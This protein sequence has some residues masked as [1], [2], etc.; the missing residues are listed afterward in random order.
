M[1]SYNGGKKRL[2]SRLA[3]QI[4]IIEHY[5]SPYKKSELI[6]P[7]CGMCSVSK[8]FSDRSVYSSD[9]NLDLIHLLR[10]VQSSQFYY[11]TEITQE[12]YIKQKISLNHS[13][14]RGFMGIV[15]SYNNIFFGQYRLGLKSDH[16]Y[17]EEA[18]RGLKELVPYIQNHIFNHCSYDELN[19]SGKLV[20]C[21]PPYYGNKIKSEFFQNFDHNK[22]WDKMREWSKSN[23]VLISES[24]APTDFISVYWAHSSNTSNGTTKKYIDNLYIHIDKYNELKSLGYNT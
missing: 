21:D 12:D 8:H 16:N 22:F 5:L 3:Q 24:T 10:E 11:P 9:I 2:G 7:F 20:Y 17:I 23:I 13:S 15:A 18:N 6:E 1:T 19:P 4:K 14:L